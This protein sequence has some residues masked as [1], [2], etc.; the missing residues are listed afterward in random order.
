[1][2]RPNFEGMSVFQLQVY[3]EENNYDEDYCTIVDNVPD[4]DPFQDKPD[5]FKGTIEEWYTELDSFEDVIRDELMD[6]A[7]V[8]YIAK[9]L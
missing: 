9:I 7:R 5:S 8:V 6:I 2:K 1:V 3:I 4:Y